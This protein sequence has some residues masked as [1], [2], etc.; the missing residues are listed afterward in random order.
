MTLLPIVG[1]ELRVASRKRGTYWSRV[2]AA[3]V[4]LVI[5]FGILGVNEL[6][7]RPLRGQLGVTLFRTLSW[8]CFGFVC[9]S[10]M[11][12]TSDSLSEEKREGTLGLLFLTDLR[13]FD[14]VLGKLIAH[15]LR[16]AYGLV[17]ALP[18]LGL[19][20]LLGGLSSDQFWRLALVLFNT[21]FFTLA[22]GVFISAVS[23]EVQRAMFGTLFV[24]FLF[25]ALT[26]LVDWSLAS[27][28]PAKFVH[29]L[30]LAS[31]LNSFLQLQPS[32]YGTFWQSMGIVH[33][34][35]WLFLGGACAIAPRSWQEKAIRTPSRMK[36]QWWRF[37]SAE[38]RTARRRWLLGGNPIRWLA[39]HSSWNASLTSVVFFLLVAIYPLFWWWHDGQVATEFGRFENWLLSLLLVLAMASQASHFFVNATRTGALELMLATPLPARHIATGQWW[40]LWRTFRVPVLLVVALR[41]SMHVQSL[42]NLNSGGPKGTVSVHLTLLI[43]NHVAEAVSVVSFLTGML[44][45][46]WFSMWMGVVTRKANM[47]VL[48]SLLFVYVLPWFVLLFVQAGLFALFMRF[49]GNT[50]RA[51]S[52]WPHLPQ[53][54]GGTLGIGIDLVIFFVARQKLLTN[55]R[56]TV[57]GAAGFG[58]P[59]RPMA[60]LLSGIPAP[61]P[62]S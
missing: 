31:P 11:F 17:A 36:G 27:W 47:A 29:R 6:Y 4:A 5:S 62:I 40:A 42:V 28:E 3:S 51:M 38:R 48:K 9:T 20:F 57:A 56:Q 15:S 13:G 49:F 14:V 1:R 2:T 24:C 10:G 58:R 8:V 12:L 35:G 54:I 55:F 26:W 33:G 43:W 61:P 19:S 53:I 7:G 21:L 46:G 50:T 18:I 41:L 30:S 32:R 16:G 44:A 60:P 59:R 52:A 37:V 45:V 22:I 25:L 23:R 34:L 39:S